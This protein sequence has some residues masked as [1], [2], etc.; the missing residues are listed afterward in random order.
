MG[1]FKCTIQYDGTLFNGYQVQ[2]NKRTVQGEIEKVLRKMHKGQ[3]IRIIGAGR[4]DAGVHALGQV[5]HF[6]STMEIHETGWKKAL[7]AQLPDDIHVLSVEK[8]HPDFHARFD[9]IEK[10]YHYFI[11]NQE[12]PDLF[13]RNYMYHFPYSLD[14]EKMQEACQYLEGTHDFTTFS[15]S[16]ATVKGDKVRTIY[17][18]S[19]KWEDNQVEFIFRGS[20]F[21][22]NMVRILVS[23]LLDIG[24][25]KREPEDIPIL[26]EKRDRR[27]VGK[28]IDAHGL[29][30]WK[31][32]YG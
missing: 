21:L 31:V 23:V 20:G 11:L 8:V 25:G 27:V 7:N 19:C 26:L 2:P 14:M 32:T 22:Y 3:D 5:I 10:E 6:D 17:E 30:M 29:Y 12:T 28:T 4:T 13:K 15:S 9:V 24:Q 1:R 18:A 16:K